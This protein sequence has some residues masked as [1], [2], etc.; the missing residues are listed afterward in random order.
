LAFL[1]DTGYAQ[2]NHS[3]IEGEWYI[4]DHKKNRPSV[5]LKIKPV[6]HKDTYE[7][8]FLKIFDSDTGRSIEWCQGCAKAYKKARVK[9][10]E[11]I[12]GLVYGDRNQGSG[13]ILDP[14]NGN[15]YPIICKL[16]DKGRRLSVRVFMLFP[17]LGKTEVFVRK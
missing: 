13:K 8:V 6:M 10:M 9:G 17:L 1:T 12:Q 16:K 14:R 7:G 11:F 15:W 3:S 5:L 4:M 2:F